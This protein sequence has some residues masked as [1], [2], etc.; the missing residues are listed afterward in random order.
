MCHVRMRLSLVFGLLLCAIL[1]AWGVTSPPVTIYPVSTWSP[2]LYAPDILYRNSPATGAMA[3]TV[4]ATY[5]NASQFSTLGPSGP[6]GWDGNPWWISA[7]TLND[8]AMNATMVIDMGRTFCVGE[9]TSNWNANMVPQ[10]YE[11][12]GSTDGTNY[13]T[14]V[15]AKAPDATGATTYDDFFPTTIRYIKFICTG[16]SA[17]SA[18]M[19]LASLRAYACVTGLPITNIDNFSAAEILGPNS[20]VTALTQNWTSCP[21]VGAALVTF[22]GCQGATPNASSP[23]NAQFVLDLGQTYSSIALALN[24]YANG[25]WQ[26][27]GKVEVSTDNTNWTTV[28][29]QATS[30]SNTDI[31][32]T[33]GSGGY[34]DVRYIRVT[35][36]SNGTN[37]GSGILE[38]VIPFLYSTGAAPTPL[39]TVTVPTGATTMSAAVYTRNGEQLRHLLL[40]APVQANQQVSFYW[41]GKDAYGNVLPTNDV[42]EWRTAY[43][44]VTGTMDTPGSANGLVGNSGNPPWGTTNRNGM[45]TD[46]DCD[47]SSN[48]YEANAWQEN[49]TEVEQLT[50][51]G[52]FGWSLGVAYASR[53]ATDG[54]YV[55]YSVFNTG[56]H[57]VVYKVSAAT[58]AAVNFS[59]L[60]TNAREINPGTSTAHIGGLAADGTHL[61]V[62]NDMTNQVLVYDENT[63]APLGYFAVT[64][65]QGIAT[66]SGVPGVVWVAT[67]NQIN[68]YTYTGGYVFT[69][70]TANRI[71]GLNAPTAMRIGQSGTNG[72]LYVI[73]SGLQRVREFNLGTTPP[74]NTGVFATFGQAATAGPMYDTHFSGLT[75]LAVDGSGGIHLGDG[76]NWRV[77]HFNASGTLTRTDCATWDACTAYVGGSSS[78]THTVLNGQFEYEVDSQGLTHAGWLGDGTWRVKN[79]WFDGNFINGCTYALKKTLYV[80]SLGGNRDFYFDMNMDPAGFQGFS[81]YLISADGTSFRRAAVVG[82]CWSGVNNDQT[83]TTNPWTWSDSSGNGLIDFT[84]IVG[85][86]Q[87]T[88]DVLTWGPSYLRFYELPGMWVDN[89]GNLYF[90][91]MCAYG[92]PF[93]KGATIKVPLDGFDALG[94]P[95]YDWNHAVEAAPP[96]DTGTAY[97]ATDMTVG[98]NCDSYL[99]GY[100]AGLIGNSSAFNTIRHFDPNSNYLGQLLQPAGL[101]FTQGYQCDPVV[102]TGYQYTGF[103]NGIHLGV[104]SADGLMLAH[105]VPPAGCDPY[106]QVPGGDWYDHGQ[107]LDV[108]YLNGSPTSRRYIYSADVVGQ[109]MAR[110]RVDNLGSETYVRKAYSWPTPESGST[111]NVLLEAAHMVCSKQGTTP[112]TFRIVRAG[113]TT[114]ALTV[115][116]SIGG[117]AVNGTDYATIAGSAVIP[118]GQDNVVVSVTP[119][120]NLLSTGDKTV[121]L[122][123][124]TNAAYNILPQNSATLT[125]VDN[126]QANLISNPGMEL[127][128]LSWT[129]NGGDTVG[130]DYMTSDVL[131][132]GRCA[133]LKG[134]NTFIQQTVTVSPNT[135]YTLSA[136]GKSSSANEGSALFVSGYGGTQLNANL[137]GTTVYAQ[138][139]ISFTTGAGVNSVTIGVTKSGPGTGKT[140]AD[141]F[142]LVNTSQCASPSFSPVA[143]T[144]DSPQSVTISTETSGATIRYTTDGTTPTET[145]GTVYNGAVNINATCTLKAI[146]YKTGLA[147]SA[148]TSGVYTINGLTNFFNTL[149][150][151]GNTGLTG[152]LGYEFTPSQNIGVTALGRAVSGSMNQNHTIYI[153]QVS[154]QSLVCS[155]TVTPSSPTDALGYKY[156]TL[157]TTVN[158]TSGVTYRIVSDERLGGDAWMNFANVSNHRGIATVTQSVWCY[159][160]GTYPNIGDA[161][162]N[163]GAVPPAFYTGVGGQCATPAFSPAP[164]TYG[165]AQSVTITCATSGTTIRYTTDGTTPTETVG[166]VYST[167]VNISSTTTLK[168]IAYKTGNADSPVASGVYTITNGRGFTDFLTTA[169]SGGMTSAG[170]WG[171]EFTPTQDIT[172]AALGRTV[173]GTMTQNHTIRIWQVSN[174]S[175]VA[176]ATV[177]PASSTDGNGYKYVTLATPVTL[178]SGTVYRIASDEYAGGDT[179]MN[180]GYISHL[181]FATVSQAAYASAAGVY[182]AYGVAGTDTGYGPPTF[183]IGGPCT[184]PTFTAA[185][186]TYIGT[187]SVTI[188]SATSGATTRYTTDGT[189]PTETVG[190]VYSTPVN[191]STTC[192]LKAI[193]YR[194]GMTDSTVTSGV[195]TIWS[196]QDVGTVGVAGSAS[197]SAG[198]F[199]VSGAGAGV[200]GT[201]DAF[202]YVYRQLSGNTTIVARI[203]TAPSPVT[204]ERAGVMMRKDLTAGSIEAS[205][206]YKPTSTYYVYFLRRTTASGSTSSTASTTAAAPPY[207]VK[208][209]RSSNT[210]SAYMSANGSSWTAVGSGTTVTMA[211]P[212]Y[213]GLAVTSGSTSAAN[214]VTFDNVSI[215]QP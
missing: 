142:K 90:S 118:A 200:T 100:T 16:S 66:Q 207:W 99:I 102:G 185:A 170:A 46:C 145:V 8:P 40:A 50:A 212:I 37:L 201:A 76:G 172:V 202:R 70:D 119:L 196:T 15:A 171:Y 117:T 88:P 203:A 210:L 27:G 105:I 189:T 20:T 2:S 86:N 69:E 162:A 184:A 23:S 81:I 41:D 152:S 21:T 5:V 213:V 24:F 49:G 132:G 175:Q 192:T 93:D 96:D 187:Q 155:A 31:N 148:V 111:Q 67:G 101:T 150:T 112:A 137:T 136:W 25:S 195:Y 17:T 109:T 72:H 167:P 97:Y 140:Y 126:A 78:S 206:M 56:G 147:D 1:A 103:L 19:G 32:L 34:T 82:A 65:P 166:T 151:G 179:Y 28:L 135:T 80:P 36:Y 22:G 138:S 45:I 58:G 10:H 123:V 122:T 107:C 165:T 197:Y 186:G 11:I 209:V 57:E 115:Y 54:T 12:D 61:W 141:D 26:Y 92:T 44:A 84:G 38:E 160:P 178:T 51:A 98:P 6:V 14:L 169:Y 153:W 190:T 106:L 73:E 182:P 30:L 35:D 71:T 85:T 113:V 194:T 168:A 110:Y 133:I 193:A 29:N 18:I 74:T 33:G 154:N 159:V 4:T 52:A 156:T 39:A 188:T 13:S 183:F 104:W 64:N 181:G 59:S 3:A 199:T 7:N 77:Q 75:G 9:V 129:F 114:S 124:T 211:D 83:P 79:R 116:Y 94:N 68:K 158:L 128:N 157:G 205:S 130:Q 60:G 164:G 42:Y 198:T 48:F 161:T 43:S 180:N 214:T 146:A 176:S 174:Q 139:T 208:L 62:S 55:F 163:N 108:Y 89:S 173:S 121:V 131:D 47:S 91:Y 144:Y 87:S 204:N 120:N 215:T 191:I 53:I 127:G 63:G 149:Y 143:G 125:I 134:G 95:L 177:T